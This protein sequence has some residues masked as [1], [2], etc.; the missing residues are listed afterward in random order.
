MT[1]SEKQLEA[2]LKM[3]AVAYT[4]D[5]LG[6]QV[7]TTDQDLAAQISQAYIDGAI[8]I[9]DKINPIMLGIEQQKKK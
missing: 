3:H 5:L 1:T 9:I 8:S 4:V 2:L 7:F 6:K